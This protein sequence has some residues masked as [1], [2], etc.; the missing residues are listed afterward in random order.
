MTIL[1]INLL[2]FRSR[3]LSAAR[4]PAFALRRRKPVEPEEVQEPKQDEALLVCSEGKCFDPTT[5]TEIKNKKSGKKLSKEVMR[6]LEEMKV[7]E[8][9]SATEEKKQNHIKLLLEAAKVRTR[10]QKV[11]KTSDLVE[12][13]RSSGALFEEPSNEEL[14]S[15]VAKKEIM[16]AIDEAEVFEEEE[17]GIE[18]MIREE[19]EEVEEVVTTMAPK[20]EIALPSNIG[21]F[22]IFVKN[23]FA[24]YS[25]LFQMKLRKF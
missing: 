7:L 13:L 9:Q 21:M 24:N 18:E 6:L 25:L 19:I 3:P 11:L 5:K 17:M 10:P 16:E 1:E 12:M 15:E 8:A 22:V 4:R 23:I 14:D 20:V 2:L